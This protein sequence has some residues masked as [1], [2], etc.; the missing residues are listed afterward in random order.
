MRSQ[1]DCPPPFITMVLRRGV[2]DER[3]CRRFDLLISDD[4]TTRR[5][6]RFA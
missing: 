4:G 5:E 3:H 1:I 6:A 2:C